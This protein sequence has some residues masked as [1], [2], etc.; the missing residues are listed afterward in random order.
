MHFPPKRIKSSLQLPDPIAVT[1]KDRTK[2]QTILWKKEKKPA[3]NRGLRFQFALLHLFCLF[4]LSCKK[5]G[6]E[7]LELTRVTRALSCGFEWADSVADDL[8]LR[9][10]QRLARTWCCK[11]IQDF[12]DSFKGNHVSAW[13]EETKRLETVSSNGWDRVDF[14]GPSEFVRW[15]E[16]TP[17]YLHTRA[18]ALPHT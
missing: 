17:P 12:S 16:T 10:P 15:S 1:M 2:N 4:F 5:T 7:P 9:W 6:W 8:N 18:R 3:K 14:F 13:N 11:Q